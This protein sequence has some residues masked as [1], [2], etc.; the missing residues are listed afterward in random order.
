MRILA[1]SAD[2]IGAG[3]TYL[4]NSL[5]TCRMSLA[6]ELRKE[7]KGMLPDY[8]WFNTSQEYK[9]TVTVAELGGVTVRQA[10]V[11]H[12][13]DRCKD[14]PSYWAQKLVQSILD[15]ADW[16]HTISIDD[17]RKL[18]EIQELRNAFPGEVVHLHISHASAKPEPEFQNDSLRLVADYVVTR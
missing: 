15:V 1:I 8:E 14:N 4:A 9:D 5:S 3:K 18:C 2:G 17:V 6:F 7:L 16:S 12:G 10:L 13:Q 11:L